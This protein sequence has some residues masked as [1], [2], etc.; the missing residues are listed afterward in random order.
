[1]SSQPIL[2]AFDLSV[3]HNGQL[4]KELTSCGKDNLV[5]CLA[6]V[7]S[8]ISSKDTTART[9]LYCFSQEEISA[10]NQLIVYESL[11]SDTDDVRVCIGAIVDMPLALLTTIQPELLENSLLR[12]W[13]KAT[14][15][16]LEGHL[17]SLGL[18]TNGT[19]K[20]LQ[21]RLKTAMTSDNPGLRRLPK[22]VSLHQAIA[23]LVALPGP[24]Y[25]TLQQCAQHLL[26]PCSV[27]S[28]DELYSSAQKES[29]MLMIKLRARGMT[30]Y[31]IIRS[32]RNIVQ[33]TLSRYFTNSR[34]RRSFPQSCVSPTLSGSQL[35]QTYFHA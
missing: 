35:T 17:A 28:D 30:I 9:Q 33:G 29:D 23:E 7:I 10:I 21:E 1:M 20:V 4:E 34:Q 22:V 26:G 3:F 8:S 5:Q 25:T 32:L 13:T 27:P 24:G 31:R 16:Q 18:D 12:S 6:R 14:K 15:Q 19:L 11:S 2:S